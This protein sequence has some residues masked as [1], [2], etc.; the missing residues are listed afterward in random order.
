MIPSI[1]G[2]L[3]PQFRGGYFHYFWALLLQFR[4]VLM[5][6]S[7]P[8]GLLVDAFLELFG[9]IDTRLVSQTNENPENVS[10]F[11]SQIRLF[12]LL[13]ALVAVCSGDDTS[14]FSYFFRETSHIGKF[15]EIAHAIFLDPLI[16]CFLCFFYR[17]FLIPYS[18]LWVSIMIV[19]GPSFSNS[20]FMSAPNS[21]VPTGFPSASDSF[22][23]NSS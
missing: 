7:I 14:Q 20:T 8:L 22:L 23:Q 21:P 5:S 17:H 4:V 12:A 9:K 11:L 6:F 13:E 1:S 16:Y 3:L 2:V 15:A 10:H 18:L 19:T